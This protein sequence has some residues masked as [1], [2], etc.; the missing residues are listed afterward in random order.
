MNAYLFFIGARQY[1]TDGRK[2]AISGRLLN[3]EYQSTPGVW[4]NVKNVSRREEVL[5]MLKEARAL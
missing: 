1:R 3:V 5:R 2:S 4:K